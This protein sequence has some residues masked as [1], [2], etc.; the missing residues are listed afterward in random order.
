MRALL[1]TGIAFSLSLALPAMAAESLWTVSIVGVGEMIVPVQRGSDGV[2]MVDVRLL[3]RDLNF[4]IEQ[5]DSRAVIRAF[6]GAEWNATHGSILLE[7]PF[8]TRTLDSPAVVTANAVYLPLTCIAEL[9]GRKLVVERDRAFLLPS[10]PSRPRDANRPLGWESFEIPKTPAEI[11]DTARVEGDVPDPARPV[12]KEILPPTHESLALDIGL[13]FAQGFSGAT[14]VTASG[15]AGGIRINFNTFLTYDR[16]GALYRSGRMIVRD[17][18]RGL[19]LE[20]GDLLSDVRGLARGVRLGK[21]VRARWHPSVSAY[22]PMG[23][24]SSHAVVAYRDELQVTKAL[25]LRAETASDGAAFVGTRWLLWRTSVDTF[26]R[27]LRS[28]DAGE[29]G[30]MVSY[31]IWRGITAQAGARRS[32]GPTGDRWYLTGVTFPVASLATVTLEKTRSVGAKTTDTSSAFGLQVPI[33]PIRVMQR[34]QRTD[35]AFLHDPTLPETGR[36]QLQS[37]VSYSPSRRV[38]L[39]YQTVTQWFASTQA[40]QWTELQSVVR[41]SPSTSLLGVTGFPDMGNPDRFRVG[42]QQNLP[43]GFRLAIDYGRLPAFQSLVQNVPDRSRFLVMVRRSYAVATPARGSS[44]RGRVLDESDQ[45]VP[46]TVVTLGP[47]VTTSRRDGSYEF[48]HVPTGEFDLALD[49]AHLP[50]DYAV[51][52]VR[53]PVDLTNAR[54]TQLDLRAIPLH[55]ISGHVY[56]DRNDNDQFDRGEGVVNVVVRL[57]VGGAATMTDSEGAYGFYNL[58][59]NH[60]QVRVDA[61]RLSSDLVVTSPDGAEVELEGSRSQTRVDLRVTLRVKPIIMQAR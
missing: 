51:D 59:P 52:D 34:Y 44:V 20:A 48:A 17:P 33:G 32:S 60:Y 5:R 19:W 6:D 10:S 31:D 12:V 1:V 7:G 61:E 38:Q 27:Y 21:D 3:A 11:A 23:Q 22:V 13:G 41:L 37:V 30:A 56:V 54:S 14:D 26:Y 57:S 28:R 9:A 50:A 4:G 53:R 49:K 36:Q 58:P 18:V 35:I 2:P 39:T 46:G 40:R 47:Y 43:R 15:T 24:P 16:D 29:R 8:G 25:G 55:A 42:L 45:P